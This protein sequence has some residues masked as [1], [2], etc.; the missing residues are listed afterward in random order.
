MTEAEWLTST[1]P[2]RMIEEIRER[3]GVPFSG[4]RPPL[5]ATLCRPLS[6]RKL[7]LF[8]CAC[9]R[10]VWDQLADSRSRKAVEVA[11]RY[12]DGLATD[13][14][15][16][17]AL[18][19][20][21]FVR[22]THFQSNDFAAEL[23]YKC[24]G[25]VEGLTRN[26]GLPR[27]FSVSTKLAAQQADLLRHIVG[28]WR[29]VK[30]Q[31]K[32]ISC[33]GNNVQQFSS[34]RGCGDCY[35]RQGFGMVR[36]EP[37]LSPIIIALAQAMYDGVDASAALHDALIEAGQ[38]SQPCPRCKGRKILGY[39]ASGS[40]KEAAENPDDELRVCAECSGTGRIEGLAKHFA[41]RGL[42][43]EYPEPYGPWKVI[44]GC[45][46]HPKSCAWLDCILGKE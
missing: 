20:A 10:Q 45:I 3:G 35:P 16:E 33:G 23:A 34:G 9:C 24:C 7:R 6:D 39:K 8:A 21:A 32:C 42:R 46:E 36:A 40:P 22:R 38:E 12:A 4:N 19:S 30:P 15:A 29:P 31:W 14:E 28:P 18:H 11:E 25:I 26:A 44:R 27:W 2:Q 1:D 41:P 43:A 13:G 37:W 17:V 5:P